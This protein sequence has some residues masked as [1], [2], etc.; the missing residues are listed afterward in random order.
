MFRTVCIVC[1]CMIRGGGHRKVCMYYMLT[2][3]IP[4][5]FLMLLD[6]KLSELNSV[7]MCG[8]E[9]S[10]LP[11]RTLLVQVYEDLKSIENMIT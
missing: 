4:H 5:T 7:I 6:N 8:N 11:L 3:H 10:N 1:M 2:Q 9:M